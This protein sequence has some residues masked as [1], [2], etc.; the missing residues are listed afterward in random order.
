[1]STLIKLSDYVR[2]RFSLADDKRQLPITFI[3]ALAVVACLYLV[4][5][6]T[7]SSSIAKLPVAGRRSIFEPNWLLRLRFLR[8]SRDILK[9]G[10]KKVR[11]W[12]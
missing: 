4:S 3:L 8:S 2:N 10:Y 1:M 7:G 6:S 12:P 5:S 9:D 11:A